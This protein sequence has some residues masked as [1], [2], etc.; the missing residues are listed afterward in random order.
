MPM[1][2]TVS[3]FTAS[4]AAARA[5]GMSLI[6]IIIV[7]VLIGAVLTFVGSRVLG[8]S[9]RARFNLAKSQ[10]ETLARKIE[11]FELDVGRLP[12]QLDELVSNPGETGWLG[13]Y[14]KA[15]ELK[16]PWGNPFEYSPTGGQGA[17]RFTLVSYG[18]D[19]KPGGDSVNQDIRYE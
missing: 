7:I 9:D 18:A 14:A 17:A 15:E 3:R 8:G 2:S 11:N 10:V 12:R 13:P 19:G 16:D 1:R 5:R 6:E 4:P